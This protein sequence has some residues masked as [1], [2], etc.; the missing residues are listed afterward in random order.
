MLHLIPVISPDQLHTIQQL[1]RRI[2][3][4]TYTDIISREQIEYMLEQFYAPGTL[5][6]KL[7][8]TRTM[9]LL[10]ANG[11]ATGYVD[12]ETRAKDIFFHKFYINTTDQRSGM[13][14]KAMELISELVPK[15]IDWRL[16]VNRENYRAVNFYFKN[17]FIIEKILDLDIGSGFFMNDFLMLKKNN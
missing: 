13:G 11:E 1:A 2:W 7:S 17:G 5:Y 12:I 15:H 14:T 16:Q 6:P 3:E 10:N 8:P 4:V 9:Y